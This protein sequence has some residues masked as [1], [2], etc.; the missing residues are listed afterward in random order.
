MLLHWLRLQHYHVSLRGL[1]AVQGIVCL[2]S[3]LLFLEVDTWNMFF[4]LFGANY[5][6]VSQHWFIVGVCLLQIPAL[7]LFEVDIRQVIFEIFGVKDEVVSLSVTLWLNNGIDEGLFLLFADVHSLHVGVNGL[8]LDLILPCLRPF[9]LQ[10][11]VLLESFELL[12][13]LFV[14]LEAHPLGQYH[15]LCY[16][17]P[18]FL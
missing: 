11:Q 1:L 18:H 9:P 7:H 10:L 16:L 6:S 8:I 12:R 2:G 17:G 5:Q 14:L 13:I 15:I 3:S 4:W